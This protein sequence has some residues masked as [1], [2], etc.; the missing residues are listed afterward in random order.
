VLRCQLKT[1]PFESKAGTAAA[2][3]DSKVDV[4]SLGVLAYEVLLGKAP[5]A[6]ASP[7]EILEVGAG[8]GW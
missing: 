2:G 7:E 3:Y 8:H 1:S 6:A 4:W 5:F